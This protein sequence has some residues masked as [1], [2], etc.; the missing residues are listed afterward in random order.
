MCGV[1]KGRFD[2]KMVPNKCR[3]FRNICP[4]HSYQQMLAVII[5]RV[6]YYMYFFGS[7]FLFFR[8][9]FRILKN[10]LHYC[11]YFRS[12]LDVSGRRDPQNR[13]GL[14]QLVS[15]H[16]FNPKRLWNAGTLCVFFPSFFVRKK[17]YIIKHVY[18]K[19]PPVPFWVSCLV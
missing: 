4:P 12:I 7:F 11:C 10:N 1:F 3:C 8:R 18:N 15:G 6:F 14:E 16:S 13:I 9:L 2:R 5:Q 17:T 19:I